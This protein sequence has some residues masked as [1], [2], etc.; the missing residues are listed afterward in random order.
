MA[1]HTYTVYDPSGEVYERVSITA[2]DDE[3]AQSQIDTYLNTK[4]GCY[5]LEDAEY[6][7]DS[8]WDYEADDGSYGTAKWS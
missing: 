1:K 3:D 5:A 4:Q 7:H 2:Q 6:E 8:D